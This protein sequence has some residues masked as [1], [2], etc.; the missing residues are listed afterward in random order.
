MR[1]TLIAT[2][3]AIALAGCASTAQVYSPV[4]DPAT[5]LPTAALAHAVA[6][7]QWTVELP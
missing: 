3:T 6:A 5:G 4:I 7:A 2:A 1:T